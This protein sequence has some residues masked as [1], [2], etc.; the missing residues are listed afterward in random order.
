MPQSGTQGLRTFH[1]RR[2]LAMV[3]GQNHPVGFPQRNPA[4]RFQRLCRLVNEY[5]SELLSHQQTVG[6]S[7]QRAGNHPCLT[8]QSFVDADFQFRGPV[9][10]RIDFLPNALPVGSFP[11]AGIQFAHGLADTPQLGVIRM[12]L[13]APLIGERQHLVVY[14]AGIPD[15]QY[16]HAPVDQLLTDPVDGHV[17]LCADQHLI[18]PVEGFINGFHQR[19]CLSR[20]GRAVYDG[21]ILG[22]QHL[23]D[24][25]FLR[26]VQPRETHRLKRESGYG[27]CAMENIPQFR[28][29]VVLRT[30]HLLDGL[31]HQPVA[32]LVEIQLYPQ[33]FLA[34]QSQQ[35]IGIRQNHHHAVFL[36][37]VHRGHKIQVGQFARQVLRKE[38]HR[39]PILEQMLNL[40][41]LLPFH[42]DDQLVQG[43]VI[44]PSQRQGIPAHAPL[45]FPSDAHQ[46]GLLL[47]LRFL[48]LILQ[49][50]QLILMLQVQH[51]RL[52]DCIFFLHFLF[53]SLQRSGFQPQKTFS[54][55]CESPLAL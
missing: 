37:I 4:G 40:L 35:R 23:V 17:A 39:T 50:Q 2:Q 5:R 30:E 8:E 29:T 18:F 41:V 16:T 55:S 33:H 53:F 44:T 34:L 48:I 46:F 31:E 6:A 15:A 1:R 19:G 54:R 20:S 14:P 3:T 26:G 27:L 21:H 24:R 13:K 38:T 49:L 28:Q 32:G 12:R 36:H 22:M 42:L 9:F 52:D 7:H 25:L 10:Q 51:R 47:E 45:D 43:V 11:A